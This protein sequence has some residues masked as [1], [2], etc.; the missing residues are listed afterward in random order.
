MV[1]IRS[2]SVSIAR[3]LNMYRE[4]V[5]DQSVL[6]RIEVRQITM[7]SPLKQSV[8]LRPALDADFCFRSGQSKYR[9]SDRSHE[10]HE[11]DPNNDRNC[12]VNLVIPSRLP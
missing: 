7:H 4:A 9:K 5:A 10:L 2:S 11:L 8:L 1:R 12:S 6:R 3:Y